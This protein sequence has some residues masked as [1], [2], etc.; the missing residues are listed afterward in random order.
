[1]RI[2][3]F[4]ALSVA[5]LSAVLL[6]GCASGAPE[7]SA[8]PSGPPVV[9][10]CEATAPS[11]AASEAVTVEGAV[12]EESTATFDLPLKISELQA[13]VIEEGSGDPVEAGQLV[14]FA[15]TGF[16]AD[17]GENMGAIGYGE[18]PLLPAQ[19]SPDNP[20]GQILGCATPGTRVVAT[21]PPSDPNA[22]EVYV[23]DFLDIVPSAAWGEPQEPVKGMPVVTLDDDGAPTIELPGGDA[24]TA[25]ELEALKKGDGDTVLSGD[26][27]LVQYT[28]VKWSDGTVFDS[29]WE[30]GAPTSF[31][32]TGVVDGFRQA[33]EGQTVG[34]QVVVVIPPAFGYGEG[35]INDADLKGET[36]VFVVDILGVE[37]APAAAQ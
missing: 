5:A 24:P 31:Q 10:L 13:T 30:A 33:L 11:G 27:V 22:G 17:T 32:T 14:R 4:A 18:T 8:S 20:I 19:I 16:N 12:G 23:F 3:P 26:T 34:S 2:R 28:G 1:M 7:G 21:F 6:A 37:H 25:V 15:L 29:S 9:D 35:E 36:L